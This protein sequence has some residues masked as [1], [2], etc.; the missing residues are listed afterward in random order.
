[1]RDQISDSKAPTPR[2]QRPVS[3]RL[4]NNQNSFGGHSRTGRASAQKIIKET[5]RRTLEVGA[6]GA[7]GDANV[8]KSMTVQPSSAFKERQ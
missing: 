4:E 7:K 6:F 8:N 3:M 2:H 5:E 1:M